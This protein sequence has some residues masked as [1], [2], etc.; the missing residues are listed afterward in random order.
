[1]TKTIA[2]GWSSRGAD[3]W[4]FS[5]DRDFN[6][7]FLL[8][9]D[10]AGKPETTRRTVTTNGSLRAARSNFPRQLR[11]PDR[12]REP[13]LVGRSAVEGGIL[14]LCP[15]GPLLRRGNHWRRSEIRGRRHRAGPKSS[16]FCGT[17]RGTPR[18]RRLFE[19]PPTCSNWGGRP[20]EQLAFGVGEHLRLGAANLARLELERDIPGLVT[21][22]RLDV[23]PPAQPAHLR[24]DLHTTAEGDG[25][26]GF[27]AARYVRLENAQATGATSGL[28]RKPAKEGLNQGRDQ[29]APRVRRAR[30]RI[31]LPRG[32]R[33]ARRDDASALAFELWSRLP[34]ERGHFI[35]GFIGAGR[36]GDGLPPTLYGKR[37]DGRLSF[38][39]KGFQI[40]EAGNRG[41]KGTKDHCQARKGKAEEQ[42]KTKNRRGGGGV[43]SGSR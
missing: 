30:L 29:R 40:P 26:Y 39:G 10:P 42:E 34:V 1:V 20:N 11:G 28:R 41:N 15:V 38:M 23:E 43:K 3:E 36:A 33:A 31:A 37:R 18:Q 25:G 24:L 27:G 14:Q 17:V 5:S 19:S 6:F 12:A 8:A 35:H 32:D 4:R 22:L 7:F 13:A 16:C 21:Q 2:T 9:A